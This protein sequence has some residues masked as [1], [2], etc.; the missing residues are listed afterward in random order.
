MSHPKT[1]SFFDKYASEYDQMTGSAAREP[2]HRDEVRALIKAFQPTSVLDAGCGTGLTSQLFA[3]EGVAVVGVDASAGMV[4]LSSERC[5]R[6]GSLAGFE[7]ARFEALPK[8]FGQKFDLV[9]CLANSL[10]GVPS[11]PLLTRSMKQFRRALKPGGHLVIQMLNPAVFEDGVPF[12]VK[13]SRHDQ[14]LYHRYALR[15]GGTIGLH[16][17]RTDLSQTAPSFETF[18]HSYQP[19]PGPKLTGLLKSVGFRQ[20]KTAGNL[21]LTEPFSARSRDMVITARR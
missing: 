13:V 17:I 21:L 4:R 2:R 7:T 8:S 10:S 15:Q 11:I 3:E 9:V 14:I 12:P 16:V 6:F 5:A 20:V 19:L 18:V 1:V